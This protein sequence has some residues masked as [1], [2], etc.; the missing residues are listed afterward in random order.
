MHKHAE[1]SPCSL[2]KCSSTMRTSLLPS[3]WQLRIQRVLQFLSR[4]V[5]SPPVFSFLAGKNSYRLFRMSAALLF[6]T[7]SVRWGTIGLNATAPA[8]AR[9]RT[10]IDQESEL[11]QLPGLFTARNSTEIRNRKQPASPSPCPA[12][13]QSRGL[14]DRVSS[15]STL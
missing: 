5:R 12:T 4:R 7:L 15:A 9:W 8:T 14:P 6:P 3:S 1:L 11:Q 13:S 10:F 2:L